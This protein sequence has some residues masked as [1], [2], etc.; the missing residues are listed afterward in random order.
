MGGMEMGKCQ[1]KQRNSC[2]TQTNYKHFQGI[3][4]RLQ[5]GD[6]CTC[7]GFL[8][9]RYEFEKANSL[10][11]IM[12][13]ATTPNATRCN[14]VSHATKKRLHVQLHLNYGSFLVTSTTIV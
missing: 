8:Q 13:F 9:R 12:L 6:V 10:E 7:H 5:L 14:W 4:G 11:E 3:Y 2:I 1:D